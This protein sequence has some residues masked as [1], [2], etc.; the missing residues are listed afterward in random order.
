MSS[1][2]KNKKEKHQNKRDGYRMTENA[3][4][5]LHSNRNTPIPNRHVTISQNKPHSFSNV[6]PQ[7]PLV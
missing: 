1:E 5:P 4:V 7:R 3:N 2:K 6:K